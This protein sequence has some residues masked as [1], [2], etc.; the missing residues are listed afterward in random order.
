MS[1][2]YHF[3]IQFGNYF[4]LSLKTSM[5]GKFHSVLF[6]HTKNVSMIYINDGV[7]EKSRTI[8]SIFNPNAM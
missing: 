7:F 5:N 2:A 6:K 4:I 8:L 1:S 3:S